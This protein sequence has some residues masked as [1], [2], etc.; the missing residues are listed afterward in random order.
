MF[1]TTYTTQVFTL[2]GSG[3]VP[4]QQSDENLSKLAPPDVVA[5]LRASMFD[6]IMKSLRSALSP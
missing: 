1:Q 3:Y 2:F 5:S 4:E 6:E